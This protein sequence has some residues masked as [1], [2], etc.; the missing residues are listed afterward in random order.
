MNKDYIVLCGKKYQ[1]DDS[2]VEK[3]SNIILVEDLY[4]NGSY[5]CYINKI[6]STAIS[7]IK[8]A[9]ELNITEECLR[10]A[11]FD[12]SSKCIK[13]ALSQYTQDYYAGG[14]KPVYLYKNHGTIVIDNLFY[15]SLFDVS[16]TM[17]CMRDSG[18][19][20]LLLDVANRGNENG[21]QFMINID[22]L[23]E[24]LK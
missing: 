8:S 13:G 5:S 10:D 9:N 4:Y 16:C 23:I 15:N 12:E 14:V 2:F 6:I 18:Y 21:M 20:R 7:D 11:L 17:I 19:N 24:E 3:I 1:F 22:K